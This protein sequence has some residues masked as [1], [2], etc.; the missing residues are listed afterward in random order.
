M[1]PP[2]KK[3][4]RSKSAVPSRKGGIADDVARQFTVV[5]EDIRAQ[6]RATIEAVL[7]LDA[8]LERTQA[9][10]LERFDRLE[11]AVLKL[12]SDVVQLKSGVG[13]LEVRVA[14]IEEKLDAKA[15]RADLR[16]VEARVTAL[17]SRAGT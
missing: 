3:A 11:N 13:R 10:N 5:L 2:S 6:N 16:A 7:N 14:R 15:D 12:S 4:V 17:E 9:E 1:A 8:K